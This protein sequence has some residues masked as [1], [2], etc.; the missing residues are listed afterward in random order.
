MTGA[1][2]VRINLVAKNYLLKNYKIVRDEKYIYFPVTPLVSNSNLPFKCKLIDYNFQKHDLKQN[3]REPSNIRAYDI[4]GNV[5]IIEI[6]KNLVKGEKNIA[7]GILNSH[8]NIKSVFKKKGAHFGTFRTQKLKLLAGKNNKE[9]IHK[10]HNCQLKLDVEKVYF[11]PRL[12]NERKRIFLQ[13]KP[14]ENV[15]VMFSGCGV[16]PITIAKNSKALK[17]YGVEINPIAHKYAIENL[18]LN[19]LKNVICLKGDAKKIVPKIKMKFNR[20][21]MPLPKGGEDFLNAAFRVAKKNTM[22]HLYDF[23]EE[24][25]LIPNPKETYSNIEKACKKNKLKFKILG[26][27]KCGQIGPR[28]F[29]ICVDFKLI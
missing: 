21:V 13:V 26:W 18:T 19:H 7:E 2:K 28:Q 22:V 3:L 29:R 11:S 6:P 27:S 1:E 16:Y 9:T 5:A 17:V 10:E 25:D 12:S 14:K 23:I 20:I 15:L 24:K 4:V 8:K